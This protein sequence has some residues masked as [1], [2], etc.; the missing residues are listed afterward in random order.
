MR[1]VTMVLG[2]LLYASA[3][4]AQSRVG[5]FGGYLYAHPD[6]EDV[7]VSTGGSLRGWLAGTDVS[8]VNRIGIIGRADGTYGDTFVPGAVVG[9]KGEPT[10]S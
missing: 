9:P 6:F 5:V 7:H 4:S 2:L 1:S 3:A 10:R 8:I